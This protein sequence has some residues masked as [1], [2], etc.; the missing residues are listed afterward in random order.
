MEADPTTPHIRVIYVRG[1]VLLKNIIQYFLQLELL[2]VAMSQVTLAESIKDMV[3]SQASGIIPSS[4]IVA[5]GPPLLHRLAA[6]LMQRP[7]SAQSVTVITRTYRGPLSMHKHHFPGRNGPLISTKQT[8]LR[9]QDSSDLLVILLPC[10]HW[11]K[12]TDDELNP[13]F[14]V[15]RT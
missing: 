8:A 4:P 13:P 1:T 14:A 2:P 9:D 12:T 10:S 7:L 6:D 11:K 5:S 15:Q 3:G